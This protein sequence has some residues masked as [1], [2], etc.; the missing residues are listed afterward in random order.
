MSFARESPAQGEQSTIWYFFTMLARLNHSHRK[1]DDKETARAFYAQRV[2]TERLFTAQRSEAF[3]DP[4]LTFL[5]EKRTH[6]LL[7]LPCC[8]PLLWFSLENTTLFTAIP[9]YNSP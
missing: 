3:P 5:C 6:P 4:A 7:Y 2:F 1:S 9:H 8:R